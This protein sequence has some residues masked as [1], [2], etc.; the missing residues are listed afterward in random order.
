MDITRVKATIGQGERAAKDCSAL[1][2][3]VQ[4]RAEEARSLAA[5]TAHDSA[6]REI[7]A[8]MA[9]LKEALRESSRVTELLRSGAESA[10]DYAS[11]L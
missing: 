6:H 11:R 2:Q 8:G 7:E 10:H 5:A 9:R 3:G 4:G 1:M